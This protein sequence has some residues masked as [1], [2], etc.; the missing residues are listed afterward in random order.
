MAA[1]PG[2]AQTRR[3]L[4]Q[5]AAGPAI[6]AR[7]RQTCCLSPALRFPAGLA[8]LLDAVAARGPGLAVPGRPGLLAHPGGSLAALL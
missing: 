4:H 3:L 8:C 6:A 1:A 7:P 2:D 5:P